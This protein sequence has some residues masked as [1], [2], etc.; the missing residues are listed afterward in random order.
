MHRLVST[1]LLILVTFPLMAWC[2]ETD[3][4][5]VATPTS[6]T[7][8]AADEDV[9]QGISPEARAAVQKGT[10]QL[11]SKQFKAAVQTFLAAARRHPNSGQLRYLL[12]FAYAQDQQFGPAWLQ[13]RKA[14][15]LQPGFEPSVR[16]FLKLWT[17]FDSKGVLSIGVSKS[18]IVRYLGEPD[19]QSGDANRSVVE[20]GFMQLHFVSDRLFAI[21]DPRGLDPEVSRPQ[22]VLQIEFD[23]KS[24]WRLGYRAINRLQSLT[25]YVPR[26]ES[27][28]DWKEM[29]TV[30]RLYNLASKTTTEGMAIKVQENLRKRNP[31]IDFQVL[32]KS[33]SEIL[34]HWREQATKEKPGQHEIVRLVADSKDIHRLAYSRR[35]AQIPNEEAQAWFGLLREAKLVAPQ[36][37][38]T[39]SPVD[40]SATD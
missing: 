34:F 15:R 2:Q 36:P 19:N 11:Q 29:Y 39:A 23:D 4:T 33:D 10:E 27:V 24:R 18:Q 7:A 14:V 30:Q 26:E 37:S 3:E 9:R 1:P 16:D 13:L 25:E 32:A 8:E 20:Y 17:D 31:D 6:K 38:T 21:V 12:G 5:T 40:T 28:Q 35:V 22:N